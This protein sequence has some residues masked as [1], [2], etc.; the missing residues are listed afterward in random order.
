METGRN[1]GT[2][3]SKRRRQ[4]R[5]PEQE[6]PIWRRSLNLSRGYL[7]CALVLGGAGIASPI[8]SWLITTVAL[9]V[10]AVELPRLEWQG[11]DSRSRMAAWLI[12][13]CM[14]LCLL[15]VVPLPGRLW[16]GL[17]GHQ[18][19][20][21]V[22][23]AA[24]GSGWHA[25]SLSPDR[26]LAALSAL[27]PP[28][29]ALLIAARSDAQERRWILRAI[30]IIALLSAALAIVQLALGPSSAPMLFPSAH[31]GLG[32][33]LFVNRNHFAL[34]LLI[35][36]LIAAVPGIPGSARPAQDAKA[37]EWAARLAA[38]ALLALGV[39]S[40]LSRSG[41]FLLP[42]AL[43]AAVLISQRRR[44]SPAV[45]AGG[46]V[47]AVVLVLVLRAAPP[48]QAVLSRYATATEDLRFRYWTNTLLA[49]RDA[50][51]LGTGFG[52]FT[53]VYPTYEP[54]SE[55]RPDVV[56][57]AHNDVLELLL[58]GGVAAIALLVAWLAFVVYAAW[59]SRA[60]AGGRR[61]RMVPI[62]AA[63]A[64]ILTLAASLTDYP[65][66]MHTIAVTLALL[67][68]MLLPT[69]AQREAGSARRMLFAGPLALLGLGVL[70]TQW[71]LQLAAIG[72]GG[73]ARIV[74]PW[75]S[76]VQAA[77]AN[78][79]VLRGD[80][81]QAL[82]VAQRTLALAPL[83]PVGVRTEGLE[84]IARGQAEQGAALLS[85]GAPL[86]WRDILTQLWLAEQAT[87]AGQDA[88][89][90]QRMDAVIRQEK[91]GDQLL[92][93]MPK[94][95]R[96]QAGRN[97]LAE[98]L[99]LNPGWR[100]AFFNQVA[101]Q[102]GWT[103]AELVDLIRHLRRAGTPMTTAESGLIRTVLA[104]NDR[105]GDM[106]TVWHAAGQ[107]ALI[108]DGDFEAEK[109]V[110]SPWAPPYAWHTPALTG[111]RTEVAA[112]VT[113][114]HGQALAVGSDGLA[115]GAA[116]QQ[117]IALVSGTYDLTFTVSADDVMLVQQFGALL[118]CRRGEQTSGL[119]N[120][121]VG[122]TWSS[123]ADGWQTARGSFTVS[124]ECPGQ[125]L[126]LTLPQTNGRPFSA[127]IDGVSI[128][129]APRPHA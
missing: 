86:G 8:A 45:V 58:E 110:L 118:Q 42:V 31:R 124:A 33:G 105:F 91:F 6:T 126:I 20:A 127:W 101:R 9:V 30:L 43:A 17:P 10:L 36:I 94:L 26:T 76:P 121:P 63:L 102:P 11:L 4:R 61:D 15:Q 28:S 83:D 69:P 119:P 81:D 59:R 64:V 71:G 88:F 80:R 87:A 97:A 27:A 55:V 57:H 16:G 111:V 106:R 18:L 66:R 37:I 7:V 100:V 104:A 47:A 70:S 46:A 40:T 56:N 109:G 13:S 34:F 14:I 22:A 103:M 2:A 77:A 122:L 93:L 73:A 79:A 82:K 129:S 74:A 39:L 99:S 67:I 53:L 1:Y 90:L 78:L 48:V 125:A 89:A 41:I 98:Q 72:A 68:G 96:T 12:V 52:T 107:T 120:V 128:R 123:G 116:V 25:W 84:L 44:L 38:L 60:E 5:K 75:S 117:V 115:Q 51:P 114:G 3:G 108:G 50:L 92:P 29:A 85:L 21:Q 95:L 49:A 35:A 54:L 24:G 65:T 32:V 23:E 113:P 62:V 112:A 19:A